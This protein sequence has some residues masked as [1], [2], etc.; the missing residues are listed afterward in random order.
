MTSG[1]GDLSRWNVEAGEDRLIL[2]KHILEV[3]ING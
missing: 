2:V 3:L 1:E